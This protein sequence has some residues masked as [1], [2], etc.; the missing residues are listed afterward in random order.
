VLLGVGLLGGAATLIA[1]AFFVDDTWGAGLLAQAGAELVTGRE[2]AMPLALGAGAP[3][4]MVA[5]LSIL[6]NLGLAVLVV[7]MAAAGIARTGRLARHRHAL[8]ESAQAAL[9]S[10][11]GAVALY[12]FMLLPFVTNGAVL[13]GLVGVLAG[14]PARRLALV[15]A[16]GV[17]TASLAWAYAY[18]ALQG[19]LGSIHPLLAWL[20]AVAAAAATLAWLAVAVRRS[21]RYGI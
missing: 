3:P 10:T 17:V 21:A 2:A 16:A 9:P 1:A 15:V 12:L 19:A 18:H 7:P 13:S 11:Q 14:M 8:R 5:L 6:Q 4:W 20:P